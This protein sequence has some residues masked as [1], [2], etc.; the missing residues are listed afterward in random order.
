MHPLGAIRLSDATSFAIPNPG[1]NV[2]DGSTGFATVDL[3]VATP[4]TNLC[5]V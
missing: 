4:L 1:S 5:D 3:L 2:R